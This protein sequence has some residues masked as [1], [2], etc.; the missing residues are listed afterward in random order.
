[1]LVHGT[2]QGLGFTSLSFESTLY[3][4]SSDVNFIAKIYFS[5]TYCVAKELGKCS[6]PP[7]SISSKAKTML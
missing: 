6:P 4:H 7:N 3:T 2:E 1:M 5:Q